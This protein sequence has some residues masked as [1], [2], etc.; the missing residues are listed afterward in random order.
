MPEGRRLG[1]AR[2]RRSFSLKPMSSKYVHPQTAH[3][4]CGH[5]PFF[6]A[7]TRRTGAFRDR[8]PPHRCNCQRI[9]AM[10]K[11]AVF[12]PCAGMTRIRFEGFISVPFALAPW[13]VLL[14]HPTDTEGNRR[15]AR[16]TSR[17]PMATGGTPLGTLIMLHQFRRADKKNRMSEW[18]LTMSAAAPLRALQANHPYKDCSCF[19]RCARASSVD[20]MTASGAPIDP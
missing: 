6:A 3:Y 14:V 10:R 8:R 16:R 7:E 5:R 18:G 1:K 13:R 17:R 20:K 19:A 12:R 9:L 2:R 4:R 15:V 11:T